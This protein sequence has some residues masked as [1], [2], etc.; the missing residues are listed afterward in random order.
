M[1]IALRDSSDSYLL[2]S[3]LE[4]CKLVDLISKIMMDESIHLSHMDC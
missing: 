4:L 1:G 3:G 2:E